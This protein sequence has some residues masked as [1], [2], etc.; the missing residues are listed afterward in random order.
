MKYPVP[1]AA[2]T[3][4]QDFWKDSLEPIILSGKK[5]C[6]VGRKWVYISNRRKAKT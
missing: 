5:L 6:S 2:R 3:D 4:S 1:E